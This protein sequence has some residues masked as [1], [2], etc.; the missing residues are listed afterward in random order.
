MPLQE[1]PYKADTYHDFLDILLRSKDEDGVGLT[2]EEIKDE[3]N[4]FIAAGE[5]PHLIEAIEFQS[6]I[7][8]LSRI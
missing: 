5:L 1:N 8:I 6:V 3:M 4:T 7:R 2:D